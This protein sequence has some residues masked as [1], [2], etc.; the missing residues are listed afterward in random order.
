M[1][2]KMVGFVDG[3][4]WVNCE[5]MK[6]WSYPSGYAKDKKA[7]I[8]NYIFSGDYLGALKVDGYYQRLVK[9]EDGNYIGR[10]RQ[11]DDEHIRVTHKMFGWSND[12]YN[13]VNSLLTVYSSET[14]A[15]ILDAIKEGAIP[16]VNDFTFDVYK[17]F[18]D[19][20]SDYDT[21]VGFMMQPGVSEIV[22]AY[23]RNKSIYASDYTK[24]IDGA[25]KAIADKLGLR[26][27]DVTVKELR[28]NLD[29]FIQ[30]RNYNVFYQYQLLFHKLVLLILHSLL[31]L[32]SFHKH[33]YPFFYN[34]QDYHYWHSNILMFY[35]MA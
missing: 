16:N 32:L 26:T 2:E 35:R 33:F 18:P 13:V 9:D 12:N 4:D 7:E 20:G 22:K 27:E 24:P 23:N 1:E 28:K 15:H 10:V 17:L 11:I 14:T 19:L 5:A 3:I 34:L 6:Y 21:C 31:F 8:R 29:S 30:N 25:I